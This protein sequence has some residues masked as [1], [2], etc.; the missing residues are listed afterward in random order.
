V[1]VCKQIAGTSER[2]GA[3]VVIFDML[4]SLSPVNKMASVVKTLTQFY[5]FISSLMIFTS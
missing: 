2:E 5:V 3:A 4:L 1:Y